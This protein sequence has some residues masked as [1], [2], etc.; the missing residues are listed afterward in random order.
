MSKENQ[1]IIQKGAEAILYLNKE[2]QLVKERI[3]KSY[4]IPLLDEKI[5][6]LRTRNEAKIIKLLEEKISVPKIIHTDEKTRKIVMEFVEGKKLSKDLDKFKLDKQKRICNKIGENTGKIHQLHIIH[7]DLTTSNMI[8][9]ESLIRPKKEKI[10]FIDFGLAYRSHKWEDRAVDLHLLRQAL[11]AKHFKH[12]KE[13]FQEVLKG[14]KKSY[15]DKKDVKIVLERLK[16]V[17]KRGRYKN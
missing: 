14:Y 6:K 13:N 8:F 5:R 11:E 3:S 17:E 9:K 4:R 15:T 7:G 16:K 10:Y 1:K 2:K 12:W